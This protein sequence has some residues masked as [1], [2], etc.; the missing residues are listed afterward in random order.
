MYNEIKLLKKNTEIIIKY[1]GKN[2][3]ECRMSEME[4]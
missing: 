2:D 4:Y 1:V 3:K